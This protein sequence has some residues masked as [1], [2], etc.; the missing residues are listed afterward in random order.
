MHFSFKVIVFIFLFVSIAAA[1][2]LTREQNFQKIEELN[3]QIKL[4]ENAVLLPSAKDSQQARKDGFDVLRIFPRERDYKFTF[5]GGGSFYSFT[6]GSHDYQKVAQIGLERNNLNVGFAGADYGFINDL[7]E[8]PLADITRGKAEVNFLINYK[9]PTDEPNIR[10]EQRRSWNYEVDNI[11]YKNSVPAVVGH[12]Y[13]LRTITFGRADVLVAFKIH[14]KDADGSLIIFWKLLENFETPKIERNKVVVNSSE[15]TVDTKNSEMALE[16][17]NVLI[18]KG[19]VNVSVEA[20]NA[21]VALRG[22]VPKGKMAD[23]V[24]IAHET[25]KRKVRNE[26]IEQ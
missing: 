21:E 19:L 12:A 5:Q 23:A 15:V 22:I 26:L 4:L 3:N 13:V 8:I 14:R 6:T 2:E 9:P 20:T 10:I 25:G 1:Q 18:E 11:S 17:Q 16:V 24:R 7:G